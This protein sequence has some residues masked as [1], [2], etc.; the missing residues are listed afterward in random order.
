MCQLFVAIVNG[1][2]QRITYAKSKSHATVLAEDGPEALFKLQMGISDAKMPKMVVSG[3]EKSNIDAK[4]AGEKR[5]IEAG[6]E[7][8]H[9]PGEDSQRPVAG[10]QHGRRRHP[11]TLYRSRLAPDLERQ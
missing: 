4:K 10:E 3:A 9:R 1:S 11:V 2:A 7:L 8:R 6:E 5:P